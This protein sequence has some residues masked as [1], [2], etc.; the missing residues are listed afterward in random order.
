MTCIFDALITMTDIG[1]GIDET[2]TA[3]VTSQRTKT[4]S[5]LEQVTKTYRIVYTKYTFI[6]GSEKR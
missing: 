4:H 5:Q 3:F 1:R 2:M 6:L